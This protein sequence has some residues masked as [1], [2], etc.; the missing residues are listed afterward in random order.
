MTDRVTDVLLT[1]RRAVGLGGLLAVSTTVGGT[2]TGI[3]ARKEP[4]SYL[5]IPR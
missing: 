2:G 4:P 1:R 3:T 5:P